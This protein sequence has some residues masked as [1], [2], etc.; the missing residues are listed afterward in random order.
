MRFGRQ[1][2]QTWFLLYPIPGGAACEVPPRGGELRV[3]RG[4][5]CL[6]ETKVGNSGPGLSGGDAPAGV[7]AVRVGFGGYLEV[8]SPP[9]PLEA[10]FL[11]PPRPSSDLVGVQKQSMAR[12]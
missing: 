8:L 2:V 10:H 6:E 5:Q 1:K 9:R 11:H 12:N 4:T 7:C 3:L